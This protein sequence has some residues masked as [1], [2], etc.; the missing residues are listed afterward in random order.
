MFQMGEAET[1]FPRFVYKMRGRD[2]HFADKFR[3]KGVATLACASRPPDYG[4]APNE[5]TP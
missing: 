5:L 2:S 4:S 3:N 1:S